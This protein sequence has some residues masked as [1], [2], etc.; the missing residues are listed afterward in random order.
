MNCPIFKCEMC[1]KEDCKFY[2]ENQCNVEVEVM[3]RIGLKLNERL[4]E[5]MK[6][7]VEKE[8]LYRGYS[9]TELIRIAVEEYLNKEGED[10]G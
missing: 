1:I 4:V 8:K 7:H 2:I 3:I 10:E 5:R 9:L 6:K